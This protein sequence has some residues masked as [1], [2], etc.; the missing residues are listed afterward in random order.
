MMNAVIYARYSTA[1]QRTE[2]ITA[3][4]RACSLYAVKHD[5]NVIRE[6]TDEARSGTTDDRPAFQ[7][8]IGD[9]KTRIVK[10]DLLLVHKL[11]RF[12]RNRYDSVVY[13]RTLLKAGVKLIA[14]DQPLDESPESE[15]LTTVLEGLNEYFILNLSREVMKGM[16]E[17][18]YQARFNGG[19]APLGYDIVDGKYVINEDEAGVIRLIFTMY[20]QGNNYRQI[21]DHL[22]SLG[23]LTKKRKKFGKNSLYEILRNPKYAGY[24]VFNRAPKRIEGHRNWHAR[25]KDDEIIALPDTVPR[26][27][28]EEVFQKVQERLNSKKLATPRQRSDELYI[29]TGVIKCGKCGAAMVGNSSKAKDGKRKRYYE[30]NRKL[31]TR[32]CDNRQISKVRVEEYVL[33]QVEGSLFSPEKLPEMVNK[34]YAM[35]NEQDKQYTQASKEL[36]KKIQALDTRMERI[37]N[38]VLDGADWRPFD[39]T[40]KKLQKQ[41]DELEEQLNDLPEQTPQKITREMILKY[42]SRFKNSVLDRVDSEKKKIIV[43]NYVHEVTI[44]DDIQ[45]V[46]KLNLGTDKSGAGDPVLLYPLP[47]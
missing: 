25:K 11:D 15:L 45:V 35:A 19:T 3:Q 43:D 39:S 21:Q 34:I 12:A 26:I 13:R 37:V 23:Y 18:A 24:Y 44:S 7:R 32:D 8:M 14:V 6:Y 16:K 10:A 9:I 4:L 17:N 40:V 22:N 41:K 2:S 1:E 31:R 5:I 27:I 33:D 30:C 28:S 38:Q 42:F 29:L 36:K 47:N 20:I 46:L